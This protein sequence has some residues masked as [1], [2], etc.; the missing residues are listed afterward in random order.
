MFG[1]RPLC[2]SIVITGLLPIPAVAGR[3]E[4]TPRIVAS[5][6]GAT[7]VQITNFS[8]FVR[9]PKMS[10]IGDRFLARTD[11]GLVIFSV[12]GTP[13]DTLA[14]VSSYDWTHTGERVVEGDES[15]IV[16]FNPV[17]HDFEFFPNAQV[18]NG[19]AW[20]PI[21]DR[22]AY[23]DA[24]LG[25][26][27]MTYPGGTV[28]PL[29]CADPDGS[30]CDGENPRWSPDAQW[31]AFEDGLEILRAPASGG[32]AEV[33]VDFGD[34]GYPAFSPDGKWIAFAAQESGSVQHLWVTDARGASFG[35]AE[36]T[37][38]DFLDSWPT[39]SPDGKEIFFTSNRSGALQVWEVSFDPAVPALPTTWG[40]VKATYHR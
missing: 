3:V 4:S 33:V 25:L 32:S 40:S 27:Q 29:P 22:V 15:G 39:W 36:V 31:V 9:G 18:N 2:V 19:L 5:L 20:S 8:A 38:G 35:L 12:A 37:S 23:Q 14:N 7:P 21:G 11:R 34:P 10:P 24:D 30:E 16:V 13:L 28:S 17:T 6:G 1:F 26:M